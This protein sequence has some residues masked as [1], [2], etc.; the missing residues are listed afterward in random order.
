MDK[1]KHS[2]KEEERPFESGTHGTS[3][4]SLEQWLPSGFNTD[5]AG[6]NFNL[7]FD[8]PTSLVIPQ[9]RSSRPNN[10]QSPVVKETFNHPESPA[11]DHSFNS[12]S[13]TNHDIV[14]CLPTS[15]DIWNSYEDYK[16]G[17]P[18]CWPLNL[19]GNIQCQYNENIP[20]IANPSASEPEESNAS[21]DDEQEQAV[22]WLME[23]DV[24]VEKPATRRMSFN[25]SYSHNH[26]MEE[27]RE[28]ATFFK[29]KAL[30]MPPERHIDTYMELLRLARTEEDQKMLY[31]ALT[32]KCKATL[33]EEHVASP[34]EPELVEES[35]AEVGHLLDV[36]PTVAITINHK[37]QQ[38]MDSV[39]DIDDIGKTI[40][41]KSK[42]TEIQKNPLKCLQQLCQDASVEI[43]SKVKS[44]TNS[45]EIDS[46]QIH[47][48]K[49]LHLPSVST[50]SQKSQIASSAIDEAKQSKTTNGN[51]WQNN[52][53]E[54]IDQNMP[55]PASATQSLGRSMDSSRITE[56]TVNLDDLKRCLLMPPLP[57]NPDPRLQHLRILRPPTQR[58][59][60]HVNL[61]IEM[62]NVNAYATME[63]NCGLDLM[64]LALKGANAVYNSN[65]KVLQM[66]FEDG[67]AAWIWHDGSILITNV[68][69]KAILAKTQSNIVRKVLDEKVPAALVQWNVLHS[70][71]VHVAQFP[72]E[73][74]IEEFRQLRTYPLGTAE[75]RHKFAYY[76][77]KSSSGVAAKVFES[78]TIHVFAM[79]AALANSMLEKL[80]LL[81]AK[82]RKPKP[83]TRI[84]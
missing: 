34:M 76:V 4:S 44:T 16:K 21:Y 73:I 74:C 30:Q 49:Q 20:V 64:K 62:L 61:Q 84:E 2:K 6:L 14:E 71:T 80:Y 59:G 1:H 75:G 60:E 25:K 79:S 65:I 32:S 63:M 29:L 9:L 36:A 27:E 42:Q 48:S 57:S 72:W 7:N 12:M 11:H 53:Q 41:L 50:V 55:D 78:G 13:P 51:Q 24:K 69:S 17:G 10:Q 66:H 52:F 70:H 47:H 56:A 31:N 82:H 33:S 37:V 77:D 45:P 28:L 40:Q 38:T 22:A 15:E 19:T 35:A 39:A 5:N 43:P 46:T 26:T 54:V 18:L 67:Q 8:L 83:R 68:P 23:S 3:L 58:N 81:T